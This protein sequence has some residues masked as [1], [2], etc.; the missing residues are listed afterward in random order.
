MEILRVENL[1]FTYPLCKAPAVSDLSFALHSGE[2]TAICGA[3]GSGKSTLLRLLKREIAPMGRQ[4]GTIGYKHTPYAELADEES[5]CK[6]GFVMQ[7][8]EHQIVT[9]KVWHELAFDL[10]NMNLPRGVIA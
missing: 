7:N 5:A 6:I 10:E 1:S 8:P 9:D 4:T 3:T 2:F